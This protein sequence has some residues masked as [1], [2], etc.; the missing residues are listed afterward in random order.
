MFEPLTKFI[1]QLENLTFEKS[2]NP[3][4]YSGSMPPAVDKFIDAVYK[5]DEKNPDFG[6]RDYPIILRKNEKIIS[7][8]VSK[9]DGKIVLALI[10]S[11]IRGERFGSGIV[12]SAI[13]S[14][15]IKTW[16]LR[17]K[18]IDDQQ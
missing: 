3:L 10:M 2:D 8:D 18:E 17:L 1:P 16:L 5:F 13:K 6:M 15:E 9:L 12:E 7:E 14:G 4:F 11:V